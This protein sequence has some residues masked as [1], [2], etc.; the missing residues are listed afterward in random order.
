MTLALEGARL[1]GARSM[2]RTLVGHERPNDLPP[3]PDAPR[4]ERNACFVPAATR[5]RRAQAALRLRH[6]LRRSLSS[7][8]LP[9]VLSVFRVLFTSS[10]SAMTL[11]PL[12]SM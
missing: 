5:R 9:E 3:R 12:S 4:A 6:F 7:I 1:P 10:I 8:S 11:A 2:P